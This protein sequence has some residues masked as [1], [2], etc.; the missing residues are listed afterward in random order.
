[1]SVGYGYRVT[2]SLCFAKTEIAAAVFGVL[3]TAVL[4]VN[5]MKTR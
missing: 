1:M 4:I 5:L 3:G 2:H